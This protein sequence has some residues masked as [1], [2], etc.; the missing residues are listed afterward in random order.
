VRQSLLGLENAQRIMSAATEAM[1]ERKY[2]VT[3][4]QEL[5]LAAESG[6][7]AYHC[8]FVTVAQGLGRGPGD[9]GSAGLAGFPRDR[10]RVGRVLRAALKESQGWVGSL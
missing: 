10:R 3:S 4:D 1:R 2:E 7:S 5:K 8:E 6:C 9:G